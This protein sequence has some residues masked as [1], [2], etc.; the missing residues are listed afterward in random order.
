MQHPKKRKH[1]FIAAMLLIVCFFL[2]AA[3]ALAQSTTSGKT[4][5]GVEQRKSQIQGMCPPAQSSGKSLCSVGTDCPANPGQTLCQPDVDCSQA[6]PVKPEKG[7][8]QK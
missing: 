8:T 3:V 7:K 6:T 2:V 1:F 4:M 5:Q